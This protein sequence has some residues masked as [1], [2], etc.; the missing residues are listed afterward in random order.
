MKAKVE[1]QIRLADRL[2]VGVRRPRP[3]LP[4]EF[5]S[6][7]QHSLL[8]FLAVSRFGYGHKAGIEGGEGPILAE[9]R[10]SLR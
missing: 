4:V 3:Q 2:I 7:L 1:I 9:S 10:F 6:H 8:I 5:L